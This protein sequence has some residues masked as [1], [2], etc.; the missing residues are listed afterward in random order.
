MNWQF[1]TPPGSDTYNSLA[2]ETFLGLLDRKSD[3]DH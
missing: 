1:I 2:R 3:K